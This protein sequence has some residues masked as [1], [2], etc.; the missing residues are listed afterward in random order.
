MPEYLVTIEVK[1]RYEVYVDA[2]D[3]SAVFEYKEKP[4]RLSA[5]GFSRL[6]CVEQ[7]GKLISESQEIIELIEG[8]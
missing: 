6:D 5:W 4:H 1:K 7:T 3:D 2:P 8:K